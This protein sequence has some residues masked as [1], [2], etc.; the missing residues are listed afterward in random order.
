MPTMVADP[1]TGKRR[2]TTDRLTIEEARA[3]YVDPEL[4][5]NSREVREVNERA[6]GHRQVL[7]AK[8]K[9]ARRTPEKP[10]PEERFA[11]DVFG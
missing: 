10:P 11:A 3:R 5:P 4:V 8:N 7:G 1:Q 9:S 2:R 6:L